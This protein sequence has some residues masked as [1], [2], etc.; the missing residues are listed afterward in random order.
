MSE[1]AAEHTA[2]QESWTVLKILAWTTGYLRDKGV[3]NARREAEW[4]LCEASGLDR[5][6]LYL[7]FDKPLQEN[8]LV[9]LRGLVARR[10][11]REPLQYLLGTQEF[12]GLEFMVAPAVLIPRH[13][14]EVLVGEAVRRM[15]HP[16]TILDIGTGSGCIAIALARRQPGAVVTAVDLSE[17]AL[18]VAQRNAALHAVEI[19]FLQGS[20]FEP[21]SQRRFDLIISNPPYIPT[22]DLA[23]L[24]PE[25]RDYEPRLALDG[26]PDGLAAYRKLTEKAG[27]HLHDGGCLVVEVGIGQA[28][29][30]TELFQAA[31]FDAIVQVP[32][33]AGIL[34]VVGGIWH[35]AR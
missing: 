31:D 4:L 22:A 33:Q 15:P 25:V 5:M 19:E 6:G 13:D 8:E 3:E 9:A 20:Y 26:G 7:N 2:R 21:V 17:E 1:P 30:V 28:V 11:R 34:R 32:D 29:Q 27:N 12:A 10:G 16:R 23:D 18:A 35:E 14:T 24:Q